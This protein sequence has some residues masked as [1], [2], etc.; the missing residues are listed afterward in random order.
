MEAK[1]PLLEDISKESPFKVPEHYF[2]HF[3]ESIMNLLPDKSLPEVRKVTIWDKTKPWI[4]MAAMFLGLFFTI[5][6]LTTNTTNKSSNNNTAST[7]F[8]NYEYWNDIEISEEDFFNYIEA[9]F[10]DENYFDLVYNQEYSSS[11]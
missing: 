2:T 11:L 4:Y 1:R 5:K 6:V 7:S 8:S 10:I 9:Q 3:N